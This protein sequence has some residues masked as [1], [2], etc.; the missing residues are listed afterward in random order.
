M[1]LYLFNISK[2][3][4]V[5]LI[6]YFC[7]FK[8]YRLLEKLFS[9]Y[10]LI[11]LM[12]FIDVSYFADFYQY[13]NWVNVH[14]LYHH[15]FIYANLM[16]SIGEFAEPDFALKLFLFIFY[17]ITIVL[18]CKYN[19]MLFITSPVIIECILNSQRTSICLTLITYILFFGFSLNAL[20]FILNFYIHRYFSF[21]AVI[22]NL[23][24]LF[25]SKYIINISILVLGI[26]GYYYSSVYNTYL[27][28]LSDY[29][30]FFVDKGKSWTEFYNTSSHG[31]WGKFTTLMVTISP[32]VIVLLNHNDNECR[33]VILPII[34]TVFIILIFGPIIPIIYRLSIIPY[35]LLCIVK[36]KSLMALIFKY[37][38]MLYGLLHFVFK[39]KFLI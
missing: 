33:R 14:Q 32:A 38:I 17:L 5:L 25:K 7:L 26:I 18:F 20:G 1:E 11:I 16:F 15:D 29:V 36:I 12:I 21:Y 6:F 30:Y 31:A 3:L 39:I 28:N 10:I 19:T 34:G 35:L 37:I 22:L 2:L 24:K 4:F 13:I 23:L 8:N 27:D 9:I